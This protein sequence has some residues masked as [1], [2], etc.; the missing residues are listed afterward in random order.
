MKTENFP[1]FYS[2][3]SQCRWQIKIPDGYKMCYNIRIFRTER[4]R[5]CDRNN[6]V[7][8]SFNSP[9]C[10]TSSFERATVNLAMCGYLRRSFYKELL[11]EPY[12]LTREQCAEKMGIDS[13][14]RNECMSNNQC[15]VFVADNDTANNIGFWL[16]TW[17]VPSNVS[18]RSSGISMGMY[19]NY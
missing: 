17:A 8:V 12:D 7:L 6:D 18:C 10:K 13:Y 3:G 9:G 11:A 1:S 5:R 19:G 4:S 16:E 2:S 15:W 14:N